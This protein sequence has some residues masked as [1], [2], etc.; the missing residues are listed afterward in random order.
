MPTEKPGLTSV[1]A[2]ATVITI[3]AFAPASRAAGSSCASI[4]AVGGDRESG[5]EE[6]RRRAARDDFAR[7]PV[8]ADLPD[9][10]LGASQ[11]TST[12]AP[13]RKTRAELRI[14]STARRAAATRRSRRRSDGGRGDV[15]AATAAGRASRLQMASCRS[16]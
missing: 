13:R 15:L 9:H 7:E 3:I 5:A 6:D 11:A 14:A 4:D 12:R 16:S 2:G 1:T 10:D 8:L